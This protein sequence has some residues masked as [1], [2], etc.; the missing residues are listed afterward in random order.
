MRDLLRK[1]SKANKSKSNPKAKQ[2]KAK[3]NAKQSKAKE[4]QIKSEQRKRKSKQTK[5]RE[6]K[7]KQSK[8]RR[9]DDTI[10]GVPRIIGQVQCYQC[11]PTSAENKSNQ[12]RPKAVANQINS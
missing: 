8:Y 5:A 10:N 7:A 3:A 9:F 12:S 2:I 6:R 1:Q 11:C 4:H